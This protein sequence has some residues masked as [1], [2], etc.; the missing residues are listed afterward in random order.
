MSPG[1]WDEGAEADIGVTMNGSDYT[2]GD[3]KF[4]FFQVD[5]IYPMSAP[6]EH[7]DGLVLTVYGSGFKPNKDTRLFL[8]HDGAA[9]F[10][11]QPHE[12]KFKMP[13]QNEDELGLILDLDL[14]MNGVD[15]Q[16]FP[17]GFE[18]YGKPT[19][20]GV[21]PERGPLGGLD[22]ISFSADLFQDDMPGFNG[23]CKVGEH[24]GILKVV[25]PQNANCLLPKSDDIAAE[26]DIPVSV[27]MNG[28][29]YTDPADF[30]YSTYGLLDIA[31]KQGPIRG[32]T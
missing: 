23:T 3:T 2:Y 16:S 31:P 10:D 8:D 25:D 13:K 7:A 9:P 18:F 12:M 26:T 15:F 32:G 28:V 5:G 11:V 29:D 27:A 30:K 1:G 4:N 22:P 6:I 20:T 19:I 24:V 17:E 21:F 14:T